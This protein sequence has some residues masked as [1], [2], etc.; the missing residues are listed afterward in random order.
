MRSV[1]SIRPRSPGAVPAR[2]STISWVCTAISWPRPRSGD[3]DAFSWAPAGEA[4]PTRRPPPS[5][6]LQRDPHDVPASRPSGFL[7]ALYDCAAP[8]W[9]PLRISFT[10]AIVS[11]SSATFRRSAS[12]RLSRR[13]SLCGSVRSARGCPVSPDHE[14]T[15]LRSVWATCPSTPGCRPEPSAPGSQRVLVMPLAAWSSVSTPW[16]RSS[17]VAC[18]RH[19]RDGPGRAGAGAT[20]RVE[21]EKTAPRRRFATTSVARPPANGPAWACRPA[22]D[23][24]AG[25]A[26][27][28]IRQPGPDT[29]GSAAARGRAPRAE[30]PG[31]R[32][33]TPAAAHVSRCASSRRRPAS[34]S[35]PS[36]S[37]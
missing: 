18:R 14:A 1:C 4:A 21:T 16:T 23:V 33:R 36:A 2:S 25:L 20:G 31:R 37:S 8:A 22:G 5:T 12:K 6:G 29:S 32:P 13:G 27:D 28:P 30:S 35:V 26:P 11:C 19:R 7:D 10:S 9:L 15:L 3:V 34:S 17:G 24:L